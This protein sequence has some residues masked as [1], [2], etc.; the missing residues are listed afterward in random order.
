M[1]DVSPD[2]AV[3]IRAAQAGGATKSGDVIVPPDLRDWAR[4][5]LRKATPAEMKA[6]DDA[7]QANFR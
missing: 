1:T 2:M 3:L 7:V 4:E 5:V 6:L